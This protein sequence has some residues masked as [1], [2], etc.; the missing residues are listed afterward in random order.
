M[1]YVSTRHRFRRRDEGWDSYIAF[2]GLPSL[3]QVRRTGAPM[4]RRSERID[5]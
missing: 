1:V 3:V 2:I 5:P 4:H